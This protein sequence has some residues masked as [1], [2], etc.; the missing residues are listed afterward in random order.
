MKRIVVLALLLLT[1]ATLF[2]APPPPGPPPPERELLAPP[3]LA[4][5]LALTDAQKAQGEQLHRAMR[6][7]MEAAH[8][9]FRRSF[10]AMLTPQQRAKFDV[11][12]EIRTLRERRH[13]DRE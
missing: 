4:E 5:F 3:E 10:A 9:Q 1:A 8:E 11:Y 2:A 7:Q 13:R 6:E 12:E